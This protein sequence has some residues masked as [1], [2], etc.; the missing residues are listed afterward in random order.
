MHEYSRLQIVIIEKSIVQ[1]SQS[2]RKGKY[3][4]KPLINEPAIL[5]ESEILRMLH[6]LF[7]I[8]LI[9]TTSSLWIYSNSGVL[10]ESLVDMLSSSEPEPLKELLG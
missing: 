9:D 1:I 7:S 5:E 4:N 6:V 2:I 10:R 3:K 8:D